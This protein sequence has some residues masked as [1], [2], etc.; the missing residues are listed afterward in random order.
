MII[1]IALNKDAYIYTFSFYVWMKVLTINLAITLYWF[2]ALIQAW[3][4]RVL[5]HYIL[6]IRVMFVFPH[7]TN[8][9]YKTIE[10]S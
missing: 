7:A 8:T 3:Q 5:F 10:L 1:A 6:H 9:A 2:D 4:V